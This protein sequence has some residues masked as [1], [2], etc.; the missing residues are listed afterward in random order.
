MA[1]EGGNTDYSL[2]ELLFREPYRFEFFQAVRLLERIYTEREPVGYRET[3][4]A[5]EVVRF[6][7]RVSYAF[8]P[9]QLY[10][11]TQPDGADNLTAPEMVVA[12]MGLTGPLGVLPHN[13]TELLLQREA[14]KDTATREFFDLFNHRLI[15]LFYRAWEKYRFPI[16]YERNKQKDQFTRHLF[17]FIGLGT[18]GLRD[19]LDLQD[20]G[21]LFYSGLIAQRPHSASAIEAILADYFQSPVRLEQ[22]VG[23]WFDLDKGSELSLGGSNSELG[24]NTI[25]GS[26]VWDR[27]SKIRFKFGPLTYSA[28]KGFLP[29]GKALGP[30]IKLV[31]FL[32][33]M[34][35]DFDIQLIL[36]ADEVPASRFG[37]SDDEAAATKPSA[38]EEDYPRLGWTSWLKTYDFTEDD[39]QVVLPG[40][41]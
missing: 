10:E 11:L 4:M 29:S 24:V 22:F 37:K 33:G 27:Q 26:R 7:A 2:A 34:E 1:A 39:E 21:L 3:E 40:D 17:D 38:D 23:Q 8:P 19:R 9:S 20:E 35:F 14:D 18:E 15:S 25:I 41:N 28:F 36:R 31:R 13:Y 30:L 32:V 12:F 5:G 6:K 16:A